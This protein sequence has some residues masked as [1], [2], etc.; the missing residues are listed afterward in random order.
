MLDSVV[1]QVGDGTFQ[2]DGIGSYGQAEWAVQSHQSASRGLVAVCQPG[3]QRR[4]SDGWP[5]LRRLVA[6]GVGAGEQKKVFGEPDEVV[7]LLTGRSQSVLELR[8]RSGIAQREIYLHFEPGQ[9]ATQLVTGIGDE[10]AFAGDDRLQPRQQVVEGGGQA[11]DL[12]TA[13]RYVQNAD[14]RCPR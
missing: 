5:G 12:V 7:G 1:D 9:R 6:G 10:R 8:V 2:P 13:G 14:P 3:E 11:S 4:Q